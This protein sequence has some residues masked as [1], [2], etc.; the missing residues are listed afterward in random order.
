LRSDAIDWDRMESW[1]RRL[2]ETEGTSYYQEQALAAML[3]AG[4]ECLAAPA[5]EYRLMPAEDEARLPTAV[6]H[7]YVDLSKK[8]YFRHAWRHFVPQPAGN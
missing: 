6:M 1:C 4:R 3:L 5:D 7:H 2:Q 8:G